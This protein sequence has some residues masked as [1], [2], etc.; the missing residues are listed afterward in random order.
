M[1]GERDLVTEVYK[2][3]GGATAERPAPTGQPGTVERVVRERVEQ[4]EREREQDE[5][6]RKRIE[7]LRREITI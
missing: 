3:L 6:L 5:A 2:R 4:R 7:Q 1:S